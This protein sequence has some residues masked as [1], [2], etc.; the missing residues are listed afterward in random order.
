MDCCGHICFGEMQL[1]MQL[2]EDELQLQKPAKE[3]TI[4]VEPV[5]SV[6]VSVS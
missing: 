1:D 4:V 2:G 3:V 6:L 5:L